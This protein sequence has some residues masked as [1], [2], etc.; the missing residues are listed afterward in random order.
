ME[1]TGT[2][3][4]DVGMRDRS[5]L[6]RGA[7]AVA[8]AA[9]VL[10]LSGAPAASQSP[11][12]DALALRDALD[13]QIHLAPGSL[14]DV[15]GE[16]PPRAR[17]QPKVVQLYHQRDMEPF[18]VSPAGPNLDAAVLRTVLAEADS[19]GLNAEAYAVGTI[20]RLWERRDVPS[21]A[22]LELLL[23]LALGDYV[24][25]LAEG[26]RQPREFDPRLFPTACDCDVDVSDLVTKSLAAPD[27]RA[28]LEDQAPPFRQY[29]DLRAK[30][31]EYRALAAAGGW[32]EVPAGP[33][34]KPGARD[35]RIADV[36]R[37]LSVTD[38][39]A[40]TGPGG[41][42]A[43]YDDALVAA[44]KRFQGRHGLDPNGVIEKDTV[45]AMNVPA[46]ARVRQITI[47]MEVWRWVARDLGEGPMLAVNIP[48]FELDA[49]RGG[50]TELAMPVIV[51]EEYHMTPVFSDRLRYV[52]VNPNWDIPTSIAA[53]EMLPTIRRDPQ[54]LKRENIRIFR[55][56]YGVNEV[57]PASVDWSRVGPA[58]MDR[59]RLRQEPGPAN[60]LGRLA[61]IFP[62]PFDVYLHD[63]PARSLFDRDKR[64][65]SHGCIRV[66]KPKDLA[67]YVLGGPE[68]GWDASRIEDMIAT[69]KYQIVHLQRPLPVCI[70]YNTAVVDAGSR[71]IRFYAD[72]YGRDAI[73][74]KAI[75]P[76]PSA[77]AV[78]APEAEGAG[79]ERLLLFYNT[80][81]QEHLA[82]VYKRGS[83]YDPEGLAK[84]NHILRD[85][86]DNE[87][88]PIDPALL[89]FLYDL[90]E[91]VDYHGEVNIVCGYRSVSTNRLLHKRTS[92]VVLGSQHT[93]GRAL[94][95]RLPGIDTKKLYEA[96]KAMQRGGT[97]YYKGSDFIQ[98]DTG[99][100]RCW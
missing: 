63:T 11:A 17:I 73:L 30:L 47:N 15:P 96:A 10:A 7:A 22:R 1:G 65:F 91:K 67:V 97:G 37:R 3:V 33:A 8:A 70:L 2:N 19:H 68:N 43:A 57:D 92:G 94:D 95:I 89:D 54:Y 18:W 23:T 31:A 16:W 62:N 88:H 86:F 38:G 29:R 71:E 79:P 13:R 64:T 61:F 74:G 50:R 84:I 25:D 44:V 27:L 34:I 28:F 56:D 100:V 32:P 80:H 24:S 77:A 20:D 51:G 14:L 85:A 41:E 39:A 98:I 72:V 42:A 59:F 46:A 45:A 90:L 49:V 6:S 87:E 52:E 83:V 81:S 12:Q 36:R 4:E 21:L 48:A 78:D 60:A 66:A 9:L 75:Y 40:E 93:L 82:A 53:K 5:Y 76:L 99:P 55:G 35:P 26:R 58:E 69:G